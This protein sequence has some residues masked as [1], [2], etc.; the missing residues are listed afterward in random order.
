MSESPREVLR[1]GAQDDSVQ[2]DS[3]WLRG[4]RA[5]SQ[6][7]IKQGTPILSNVP[8]LRESI[9]CNADPTVVTV[10]YPL[11]CRTH[12]G[13]QERRSWDDGAA[14]NSKK[15]RPCGGPKTARGGRGRPFCVS[16]FGTR[17]CLRCPW[18]A[19]RDSSPCQPGCGWC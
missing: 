1:H 11:P 3:V 10:G 19:V 8:R 12:R 17:C 18:P 7:Q 6:N 13:T 15:K 5:L 2:D 14:A 16:C 9:S 4:G